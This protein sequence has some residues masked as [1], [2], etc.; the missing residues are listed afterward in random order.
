M[1]FIINYINTNPNLIRA[2]IIIAGYF[3]TFSITNCLIKKIVL[4]DKKTSE[5]NDDEKIDKNDE[6][7]IRDGYINGKCENIIILSFV[8]AVEITGLALIFADKKTS[9]TMQFFF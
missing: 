8:L 4:K 3:L 9:T 1:E 2:A 7:I 5:A 6:K